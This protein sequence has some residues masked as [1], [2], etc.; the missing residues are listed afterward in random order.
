M[1]NFKEII[2]PGNILDDDNLPDGAKILYGKIIRLSYK[3]GYCWASNNTLSG[4]KSGNTA[5]RNVKI[6]E[7]FGYIKCVYENNGQDRKIYICK[8]NSKINDE[9]PPGND[10][11]PPG[12]DETP[13]GNDETS[14][15][16]DE[17]PSR[18]WIGIPPKNGEQTIQDKQYKKNNQREREK[19]FSLSSELNPNQN[20]IVNLIEAFR[21]TWNDSGGDPLCN[22][23]IFSPEQ[24]QKMSLAFQNH[25]AEKIKQA[26]LNYCHINQD[27]E[28]FDSSLFPGGKPC[29]SF[30]NFIIRWIQYFIDEA[31]PFEKY[32]KR[33]TSPPSWK[34]AEDEQ[35]KARRE[36]IR[37]GFQSN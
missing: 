14:P 24:Y 37:K 20:D 35:E 19:E 22:E 2:I 28:N 11:T 10:E 4:T 9:T 12:N 7:K 8:I 36:R 33:E 6:L 30:C 25:G 21:K 27:Q 13:P 17:T 23:I 3:N 34:Q 29:S 26:V 1:G 32:Q 31:K 16:N 15:G 18:K 5:S